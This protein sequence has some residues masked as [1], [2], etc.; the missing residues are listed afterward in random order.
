M[1]RRHWPLL[2]IKKIF[3]K[4]MFWKNNIYSGILNATQ[5]LINPN[6]LLQTLPQQRKIM[7]CSECTAEIGFQVLP[8][9]RNHIF[10]FSLGIS[11]RQIGISCQLGF[12]CRKMVPA[13]KMVKTNTQKGSTVNG[14]K[15]NSVPSPRFIRE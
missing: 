3:L 9:I 10:A 14:G 1:T 11:T 7:L 13:S 2:A 6:A 12:Q 15:F 8:H 5:V 4:Y